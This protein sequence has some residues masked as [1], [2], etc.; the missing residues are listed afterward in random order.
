MTL[1]VAPGGY[2]LDAGSG[3]TLWFSGDLLTY[4]RAAGLGLAG[5]DILAP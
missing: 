1:S 5:L 3:E 2:L 4:K